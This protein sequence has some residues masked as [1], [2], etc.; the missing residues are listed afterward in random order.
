MYSPLDQTLTGAGEAVRLTG[1]RA[2]ASL[3]DVLR[4]PPLGGRWFSAEDDRPGAPLTVV[5]SERLWRERFGAST[6][7]IAGTR[8]SAS[9]PTS[10]AASK[11]R[12]TFD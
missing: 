4:V 9:P 5:L 2:T 7:R 3:F 1:A 8:L 11:R 10:A 6:T 12:I